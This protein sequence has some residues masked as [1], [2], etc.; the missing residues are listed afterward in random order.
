LGKKGE[1]MMKV[2]ELCL[3]VVSVFCISSR[4]NAIESPLETFFKNALGNRIIGGVEAAPGEFPYIVSLQSGYRG[5][6]CGGSLIQS[7]WVLTAAH[8]VKST[9]LTSDLKLVLGLYQQSKPTNVETF[10]AKKII[11]H[12][13]Y[14]SKTES[15]FDFALVQ[16]SGISRFKPVPINTAEL[17]IPDLENESPLATTAG[18]G[19]TKPGGD[20]SET[21]M[22]VDVPLVSAKRCDSAYPKSITDR[23]ICAGFEKGGKDSCQGDSGGPLLLSSE[24]G[25]KI[26]VGVVSWGEG[27]ARPGKYGV[28]SKINSVSRWIENSVITNEVL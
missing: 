20:V 13:E 18:W 8:C 1:I 10:K 2:K 19:V 27:C 7:G 24:T 5:H 6:F 17:D 28:Y 26:L 12:P 9:A 14:E 25:E 16:L 15:D 3:I 23:M 21:L 22:K 4:V 11:I